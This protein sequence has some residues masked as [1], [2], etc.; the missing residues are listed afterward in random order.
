MDMDKLKQHLISETKMV[1]GFC[2]NKKTQKVIRAVVPMHTFGHPVDM[3]N[4]IDLA[5]EFNLVLV[6]DAAE[7]LGS[8][9]K[10]KQTGTF[11]RLGVSKRVCLIFYQI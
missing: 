4:L 7:S 11:G 6:E 3:D 1:D 2:V 5:S 10:G 8:A 9:Y